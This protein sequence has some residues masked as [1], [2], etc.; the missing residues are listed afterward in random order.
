M[1]YIYIY[2]SMWIG[3]NYCKIRHVQR[4]KC[5]LSV[6]TMMEVISIFD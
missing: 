1:N 2:Y 3:V 5:G 4:Y 6:F